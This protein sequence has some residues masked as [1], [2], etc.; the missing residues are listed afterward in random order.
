[1]FTEDKKNE[2]IK[3]MEQAL[4]MEEG[5]LSA[6]S[7]LSELN[8]DSLAVISAIAIADECFGVVI[9]TEKVFYC[10]NLNDIIELAKKG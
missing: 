9:A 1:M 4:E 6:E 5:T 10:Q 7:D 3:K 2:F 8:W